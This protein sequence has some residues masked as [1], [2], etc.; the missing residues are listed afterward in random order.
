MD[1][2]ISTKF[3]TKCNQDMDHRQVVVK[4]ATDLPDWQKV[5]EFFTNWDVIF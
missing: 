3:R 4:M 1:S 5:E 2:H